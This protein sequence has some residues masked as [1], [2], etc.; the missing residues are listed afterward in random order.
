M[1]VHKRIRLTP[2]DRKEIWRL[3]SEE[4]WRKVNLAKHFRV[5]RPTIDKVLDRGH[6]C[7]LIKKFY[8]HAQLSTFN[9][10]IISW[11]VISSFNI[12]M[13]TAG[14]FF[15]VKCFLTKLCMTQYRSNVL[16]S[17]FLHLA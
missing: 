5:S 13:S 17:P 8:I 9:F 14:T 6:C 2:Y 3:H 12:P 10:I 1:N 16:C 11:R 7:S 4:Q 15:V